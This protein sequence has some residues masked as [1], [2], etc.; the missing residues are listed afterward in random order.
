MIADK[1][2]PEVL[3]L[4]DSELFIECAKIWVKNNGIKSV[5]V[6]KVMAK[7]DIND[8]CWRMRAEYDSDTIELITIKR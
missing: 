3:T 8:F 6:L 2:Y 7:K 5:P 1:E 4:K